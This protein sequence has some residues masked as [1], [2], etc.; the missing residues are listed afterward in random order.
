MS[1]IASIVRDSLRYKDKNYEINK[2]LFNKFKY[3]KM[4]DNKND[5][6]H[7]SIQFYDKNKKLIAESKFEIVSIMI[8]TFNLWIWSWAIPVINNNLIGIS[9][10]ILNY[11]LSLIVHTKEEQQN[12]LQLKSDL[13]NSRIIIGSS[14]QSDILIGL[15]S[16]LAKKTKIICLPNDTVN[17]TDDMVNIELMNNSEYRFDTYIF[18]LDNDIEIN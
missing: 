4:I 12:Y 1:N 7:C 17:Y 9:K 14:I 5:L 10:N 13:I 15:A 2:I 3:Y 8:P 11:G 6:A 18:L 16:Y